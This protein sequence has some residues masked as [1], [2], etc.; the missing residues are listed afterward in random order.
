MLL[1]LHRSEIDKASSTYRR[2]SPSPSRSRSGSIDSYSPRRKSANNSNTNTNSSVPQV[3]SDTD[4]YDDD[5]EDDFEESR[6]STSASAAATPNRKSVNVSYEED[7]DNK[8]LKRTNSAHI[9]IPK[10][11]FSPRSK[12]KTSKSKSPGR[13]DSKS[14]INA[15][16]SNGVGSYGNMKQKNNSIPF[17]DRNAVSQNPI[18]SGGGD[19]IGSALM[20]SQNLFR[21]QLSSLKSRLDV[22]NSSYYDAMLRNSK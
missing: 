2:A 18:D 9:N 14:N 20:S 16:S 10:K 1:Q 8:P 21:K 5:Y 11:G 3:D 15:T 22:A 12:N 17:V 6:I 19:H 4:D 7:L 13:L